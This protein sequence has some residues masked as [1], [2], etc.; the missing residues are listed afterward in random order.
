M[1][2]R[3]VWISG[4]LQTGI[5][6]E[7]LQGKKREEHK[8]LFSLD[9]QSIN[10]QSVNHQSLL[11]VS[12]LGEKRVE[13]NDNN[14]E[15]AK[16]TDMKRSNRIT[17][18]IFPT[19]IV[20][21]GVLFFILS[22]TA[23]AAG[24][25]TSCNNTSVPVK[26]KIWVNGVEGQTLE[27]QSAT[28]SAKI[29]KTADEQAKQSAVLPNPS[30]CCSSLSSQQLSGST[31][32]APRGDCDYLTKAKMAQSGDAAGLVVISDTEDIVEM[33]CSEE[34]ALDISIPVVMVSKLGGEALN[35]SLL[36]GGT[37]ELL[38]YAPESPI[39]DP[40]AA[41]LWLMAVATV[42]CASL[43]PEIT[44]IEESNERYD[45]LSP[46]PNRKDDE[47]NEIIEMSTMSAVIFV[48]TA[49]TFLVLLYLFMSS[50]FIWVLIVFFCIGAV[51]GMHTCIVSL[52]KSKCKS[53]GQKTV[54]VPLFGTTTVMSLLVLL[55]CVAFA[56]FWVCT[57]KESYAWVG[58]DILGVFLIIAVLQ[59]AQ[60]P[61]IK[62]ATVLLCC[63]F[64]YDI[65]WVFISPLFF[66]DSVMISVAKGDSSS[67]ESIPMVLRFPRLSDPW[68]GY[69]VLGF[70]DI[71]FPG[72]LLSFTVRYDKAKKRT[73]KDGYFLWLAV[74]YACGL[75][76]TYL[77]LYLMDGHG[78]PALL[79]LVPCTLGTCIVL[80]VVRGE[81]KEL[82]TYNAT[83]SK[84]TF[85]EESA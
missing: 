62:V 76:L 4:R 84:Q 63:A 18:S 6:V 75:L 1:S 47:E 81:M 25:L 33:S 78:Q 32:L 42:V 50:W 34:T 22:P 65:F 72:L 55:F 66:H 85:G 13:I 21:Y 46:K 7:L 17:S 40:A 23:S 41:F 54:K 70:G 74:G 10:T 53:C 69:G 45:E 71:L 60:I 31:A 30:N 28:F 35:K 77:G 27:G 14:G 52:I 73:W 19:L 15:E 48:I 59:L 36:G 49:S 37:V 64:M 5:G 61:N 79:Y 20:I 29:P 38:L 43:W 83:E 57:R 58:Q 56:T 82:W 67:G 9:Y 3:C 44:K 16:T 26:I 11:P 24:S 12:I 39:I 2:H 51:E 80:G 8:L 68:G